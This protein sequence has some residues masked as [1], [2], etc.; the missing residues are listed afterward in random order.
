MPNPTR[1]IRDLASL[2]SQGILLHRIFSMTGFIEPGF[3]ITIGYLSF[4]SGEV[5]VI[6][7]QQKQAKCCLAPKLV[8]NSFL[9]PETIF[10]M[11]GLYLWLPPHHS[12]PWISG[13]SQSRIPPGSRG[14]FIS[15]DFDRSR[16]TTFSWPKSYL[17]RGQC[18]M[19][20]WEQAPTIIATK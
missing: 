18:Q 6:K 20:I 15:R 14:I 4:I 2:G 5:I 1:W 9:P 7:R 3:H 12:P 19:I 10:L 17:I 16:L 11:V 13:Q 8:W